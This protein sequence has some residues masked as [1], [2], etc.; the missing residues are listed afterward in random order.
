MRVLGRRQLEQ[1][2]EVD[3]AGRRIEQIVATHDLGDALGGV[4]DHD[5]QVVGGHAVVALQHDVVDHPA[6]R[7][8]DPVD[9]LDPLVV[10]AQ[11]QCRPATVRLPRP[12]LAVAEVAAC[13]GVGTGG[14]CGALAASRI[15]LRLQ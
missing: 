8:G 13:A 3:L 7:T 10:A 4:V 5:G 11:A 15:S 9:E 14:P 1:P 6:E 12:P 2:G